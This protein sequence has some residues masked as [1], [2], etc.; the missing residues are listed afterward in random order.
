MDEWT[1]G[2]APQLSALS[3]LAA[4]NGRMTDAAK[5]L[6]IPQS[7][8]SRR[9][10]ALER[11]LRIPLL[12]PDGRL[13]RLT[14]QAIDLA[15]RIR[16]SLNELD[17]VLG[18]VAGAADPDHGAVRFGFPLTMGSGSVPDLLAAFNLA[19]PGVRLELRQ[20]HGSALVD[21]LRL[22]T[23]DLAIIIPPPSDLAHTVLATQRI[24]VVVPARHP[25]AGREQ[26]DL[27][28]LCGAQFIANPSSYHLRTMTETWCRE[29]GFDPIVGIEITEFATIRELVGRG[30]G[31]ALLP[32]AE[33]SSAGC[34][35]LSLAGGGYA[36]EIALSS[37]TSVQ[38]AVVRRFNDFV[39]DFFGCNP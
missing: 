18:E 12:V 26:I 6:G 14:P 15:Q 31:V 34:V 1:K 21:G 29:A 9:V 36:R 2:L 5:A 23:L 16:G 32:V 25:L 39:L 30:L 37:A 4:H 13:A 10:H 8:M 35:Q 24:C 19:H 11:A 3:A 28:E 20:A 7:S 38:S 22:S 33:Q 27:D 17:S